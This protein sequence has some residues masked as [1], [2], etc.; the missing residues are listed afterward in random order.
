MNRPGFFR[1]LVFLIARQFPCELAITSS[2]PNC[3]PIGLVPL[4]LTT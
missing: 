3:N 4:E 1:H 2:S